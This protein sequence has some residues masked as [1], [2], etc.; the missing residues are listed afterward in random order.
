MLFS[1]QKA[2]K[3]Y[4]LMKPLFIR[5]ELLKHKIRIFT[6]L[7]FAR[8]FRLSP[9]KAEYNIRQF[10]EDGLLIRLKRGL[11]ALKTDSPGEEE[12]ANV[13]YKPSY[14]SLEYALAYYGIIPE[15]VYH[16]TSV[17]TKPTRRFT[18]GHTV[19]AY[20][21]IKLRAYTGYVFV[22]SGERRFLIAEPEKALVDYLYTLAL[23][24]RSLS[25][26]KSLNDRLMFS[27]LNRNK[28]LIFAKLY[29]YTKLDE[30]V[31]QLL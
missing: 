24:E 19:F 1:F 4:T 10:L 18:V 11:Y 31:E 25:G 20:Q 28:I 13:L 12:I 14:I 29:N 8:I 9:Y 23:G 30:L 16:L 5:E 17:T 15:M 27:S 6:N 3:M 26:G 2:V 21:T 22:Q 7:E